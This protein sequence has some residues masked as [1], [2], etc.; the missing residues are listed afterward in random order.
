[1]ADQQREVS[2]SA[3]AAT[4]GVGEANAGVAR[5]NRAEAKYWLSHRG[6]PFLIHDNVGECQPQPNDKAGFLD[7]Y[8]T[9]I[10]QGFAPCPKCMAK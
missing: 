10:E 6:G 1:M 7:D 2:G 5:D 3:A 8:D 9:A 4:G